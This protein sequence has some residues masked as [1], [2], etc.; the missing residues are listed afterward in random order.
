MADQRVSVRLSVR[1]RG[2]APSARDAQGRRR[3]GLEA[4]AERG[5]RGL[6][7]P[8]E[9]ELL[10]AARAGAPVPGKVH[11]HG[12]HQAGLGSELRLALS[13]QRLLHR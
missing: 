12:A 8:W 7:F 10:L 1:R 5:A 11:G 3:A 9:L 4:H 6:L 2:S 13:H